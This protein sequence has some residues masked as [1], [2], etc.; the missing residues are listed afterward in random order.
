VLV[1]E[2]DRPDF[3]AAIRP[4]GTEPKLKFYL[5]GR[6]VADEDLDA[7]YQDLLVAAQS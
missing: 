7:M 5:F 3:Y 2:T 6:D 4:S 1:L